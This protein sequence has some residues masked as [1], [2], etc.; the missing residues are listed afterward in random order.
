MKNKKVKLVIVLY[1]LAFVLLS[2]P[3]AYGIFKETKSKELNLSITHPSFTVTFNPTGG[4]V[5]PTS[6]T[7]T[8]GHIYDALPTPSRTG[9]GFDG[10]YDAETGGNRVLAS[11]TVEK[12]EN[13]TLF[14]H[15][16]ANSLIV[17]GETSI[18]FTY[19]TTSQTANI[20]EASNGSGNYTYTEKSESDGTNNTNYISLSGTEITVAPSTPAGIYTYIVTVKDTTSGAEVDV[21]YTIT[22][23][24]KKVT[25]PTCGTFTYN[26]SEQTLIASRDEY[27]AAD[28]TAINAGDYTVKLTPTSNY[29][30]NDNTV[31]VKN[32]SC[33]IEKYDISATGH[34]TVVP[35][36]NKI[37]NGSYFTPTP[38]VTVPLPSSIT[39]YT[40]TSS[41]V[42][43][44]YANNKDAGEATITIAGAGNYTGVLTEHFTIEKA[45]G[46]INLSEI[47]KAVVYGTSSVSFTVSSSHGGEYSVSDNNATATSSVSG[48][49]VTVGNIGTLTSGTVVVVTVTSDETNNYT[50]AS[51]TYTLTI[52]NAVLS[53]G[54]VTI[55]GRNVV[56]ETLTADV[57]DTSPAATYTYEWYRNTSASTSGGTKI[58]GATGSTYQVA[59]EDVGSYIYVVVTATKTNYTSTTFSDVV[60]ATHNT[61]ATAKTAVQ[62]PTSTYCKTLAY[63]GSAQVLTNTA[64]TGFA[65][66]DNSGTNAGDYTV[67]A[68]LA[69][70]Y[71]WADYTS[72]DASIQCSISPKA[73]T[74]TSGSSTREYNGLPL[75]NNTCTS[76][77]L[78]S[79]DT[80]SCTMTTAST[81]T[82]KGSQNN[83]IST[84]TISNGTDVV[85]SNY[86]VATAHG[87]LTVTAATPTIELT[88]KTGMVWNNTAQRANTATVSLV[89]NETY[90]GT[91]TYT[92]YTD[93]SC[94]TGATTTAPTLAGYYYVKATTA[95]FGNYNA[96]ASSC[97]SHT[98]GLRT[99]TVTLTAK[100]ASELVY[101]GSPIAANL[102]SVAPNAGGTVTYT[103]YT[104]NTCTA[105][106][107]TTAPTNAGTYYVKA[108]VS[109]VANKT[110]AAE[111]GCINH[112]ITQKKATITLTDSSKTLTYKTSGTNTYTYDGDG[113]VNC[114]SS[115]TSIVS[116]SVDSTNNKINVVPVAASANAVT[117]TV[118]A[119]AGS[120][121][122]APNNKTFTV[123]VNKATPT[124]T[125]TE[126]T[127]MVWNNTA[128]Q[129]NTAT[130][131]LVNSET[132]SGTVTYTYYTNSGCSSGAT[133]T[134][135]TLAG[136]YYVKATTASFGNYNAGASSCVA[137]TIGLRTPTVT[138][139]EK[140]AANRVYTGSGIAA[141]TAT[142]APNAGGA[143]TYTYYT[144]SECTTGGTTAAPISV[145]TY[146]VKASVA[147]V[148][149]KTT[150]AS[151]SCV[152]HSITQKKATITLTDSTKTL[153]YKTNGTNSFTYDGDGTLS[154][155]SSDTTKVTCSVDVANNLVTVIPQAATSSAVTITVSAGNGINY[156]AADDKTF[157]VT[158]NKYT[159]TVTLAAKSAPNRVYTGSAITANTATVTLTNGETYS[160]TIT[161]TY[162][163]NSTC[164]TGATTT[165][166]TNVGTYYVKATTAAFGNYN[167]GASACVNHSITQKEAT[168]TLTDS[169]KTL[170]YKTSGTNAYTYDGDGTISC[171]S[172]DTTKVTCSVDTTNHKINV[173]PVA[174]TTSAVT[175]TVSATAGSNYSAAEDK[176]FTVT[177]NKY[178]PT[179]TLT[180]K[181]AEDRVYTGSPIVANTATVALTNSE[182]YSGTITYTYYTNSTCTTGATTTAPTNVGTY[183]VKATTAAFGNYNAGASAC[184]NH[185]ITNKIATITLADSTMTLTYKTS[186]T[187][188]YTYDGDGTVSCS[189]SNT[190]KVTCSVDTTNHKIN[191]VPV[192][193]TTSAVTITVSA[194]AGA[195]YGPAENKTFTVTVN[196]ATPT[197]TLTAKSAE[198]R[199]YTGS[200]IA[201]NTATVTLVN[202]ETYSG[203]ITYTYY[204]NSTCTTGATTTAPTNVGTYYAKAS[205]AAFGN[206]NAA[207]SACVNH[208]ITNKIATIT[209]TDATKT[210]TYKTSGTNAYT[211]DGDGSVS[212]SSSDTTKVTCSVDAVNHKITV[213]PQAATTSAVTIT[214][215]A[216]AGSNY[217]PAEDKT[218][219]VT[220]NK[221][222]P[223]VTLTEKTGM[224]WNNTA[225]QANTATVTLVN[226]E[227]YSGTI[228]YTYYT[229][230]TCTT[231]ATTTAPTLAGDYY[232][233]ATT[234]AFGNYN[235]GA[236]SCV[237]HTIG[238]RTPT[239]TLNA[240]NSSELVYTGSPIAAN[241]A[242]VAPNAGGTVTYTY[243]TNSACTTGATTTA[244]TAVGTYYVK[245]SVAAVANKT[246]TADSACV[247][248]SITAK[249]A[250]ITLTDTSKTLTYGTSGT[251]SY[252]YD[253]DGTVSCSSSDTSVVTCSVDSTNH[254]INI[255]PVAA[256]A[257]AVTIT[258]SAGAGSNYSAPTNKTFTVVVNKATP[259]ISLTEKTG[260]VWNNTAQQANTATVTLVNSET[261]SGT[262]TYTYYT[263]SACSTGATTTAPTLAGNYYVKATTAAFGNYNAGASSCVAHTIDL[264]TPTVTLSAKSAN[265]LV[266]TGS[267]IAA[268]TATVAPNAGGA[269]TYTYY[270]N[271]TCTTGATTTAPTNVGTYYVKASVAAVAN[272]TTA[273]ESSC[274]AH[275][276]TQKKATI[277]LTDSSKTLT[278]KT[279][280]TNAYTYDG[281]GTLSCSSS[282]TTK[283]TCSVDT[284]NNKINIVPVAATTSAVT[285]TVSATA[286]SNYSAPDNKT[287][288]V[289]VNKFT[290]TV[291]LTAKSAEDRVYTGSPIVANT[292]TV[293]LTN[294]ETY[295]GTITYTY[296]TNS[297][298]TTGA[299]TTAPTN[300]GT[301]YV[302][303]T[304]SAFG[305]Y[306]AGASAC[307]NHSITKN[308]ATITITDSSKTLTYG[309]NGTNS[310]TYNGDGTVS[311]SSTN[312]S[313]VTCSVDTTNHKINLV[314]VAYTTSAVTITVSAS[315]GANYGIAE[316]KT[317]TVTV[318]KATPTV[319]LTEKSA[320]Q[321]V[322]TGSPITANTA[323][324]ALVNSETYTGSIGYTY[325]TDSACS[326]G[327]TTAPT[328]AGTYYVKATTAAFGNYNAGASACVNHSITQKKATITLTDSSKTLTYKT[329]GTN[330]YTYD[331]D[332]T[333]GCA[334]AD[335]TKVT[336]SVDTTNHVIEIVPVAATTSPVTLTISAG[337]GTNYSA[338][339]SKTFT[340]TV[341]KFTPTVSLTEKTGMVWNNAAQ[342]A[343]TATVTLT[344][345]ETFSRTITYTYYTN[346]TCTT[347]ATT[348]TPTL[349]GNY[350]V[351]AS[352]DAYG[353]Y[354]AAASS[355]VA[356]T[357]ALKTPTV[358]LTAKSSSEL[359]YTGSPIPSNT[360][361]V[362]T[363]NGGS[364]IVYKYYTNNS[365]TVEYKSV[366]RPAT[367]LHTATCN[368][369]DSYGCDL[370][371]SVGYGN[372]ITYGTLVNGTPKAGDAY[373][374]DVNNDG[375]Y[376][377]ATERFYYLTNDG[378]NATLIYYKNMNNLTTYAYDSSNENWHGPR[379]A[380]SYLP[381]TTDWDNPSLIAPGTRYIVSTDGTRITEGGT[382]DAFTYTNRAARLLTSQEVN[383]A[384]GI[385]VGSF[386]DGEINGCNYLLEN[387]GYFE[388]G[389][390][391]VGYWLE[392]PE[393]DCD[394]GIWMTLGARNSIDGAHADVSTYFGVR[395]V[396]TVAT[397][398]LG[399]VPTAVGTYYAQ[400][401]VAAVENKT[402][403]AVSACVNHSITK[404]TAT[405]TV[406]SASKSITYGATGTNGYT[407]TGDGSVSCASSDSTKVICS[408]DSTNNV[409]N[410]VPVGA[411]TSAVTITLSA[412]AGPN[413]NAPSNK[414]FTVTVVKATPTVSLTSRTGMV[415]NDQPYPANTATVT[416]V[417][418]ETY[419]GIITYTYYTNNS[420]TNNATTDAPSLGRTYYVKATTAAFGNYNAGSSSCVTH[421]IEVA[422][423][424]VTLTPKTE[425]ERAYTG[426][427]IVA[428]TATLVPN[429]GATI[430]YRYYTD[431]ACTTGTTTTAPKNVGTYYAKAFA[432]AVSNKTAA[433]SSECV[434]HSIVP[435][436]VN[437]VTDLAVST[438]GVVTWTNSSNATGYE[439]SIDGINWT[440]VPP[441]TNTTTV[442]YL[443]EITGATGTRTVYVKAV[444][445]NTTNYAS[446]NSTATKDVSVYALTF[447]TNN[448][449]YGVVD[450]GSINVI[451]GATYTAS[452]NT[453]NISDGRSAIATVTNLIG[454]TTVFSNWSSN[455]GTVNAAT[456][457]TATFNRQEKIVTITFNSNT[458]AFTGNTTT[459]TV[460]YKEVLGEST[461]VSHTQN[462]DDTGYQVSNYGGSWT[463]ANITGTDRGDTTK[464]HVITMPGSTSLTV[465]V[466]YNGESTSYDWVNVWE[467]SH[468]DYTAAGNYSSS[469]S[470]KLGGSQSGS[471]TVNGNSLTNMGHNTFTISGESVTFGFK[472]DGSGYG[473]G[474]GYYAIVSGLGAVYSSDSGTYQ[475]PS[476][477]RYVFT[478]WNTAA[479]GSGTSYLT[480]SSLST[481]TSSTTLYAQYRKAVATFDEGRVFNAAIKQLSGQSSATYSTS[482]TT[483]TA[484]TK[485]TGT[486]TSQTLADAVL[487]S[488]ASSEADIYAWF[489]NG[490]IYWY[491]TADDVYF[492]ATSTNMFYNLNGITTLDLSPFDASRIT[493]ASSMLSSMSAIETIITPKVHSSSSLSLPVT[494]ID[495]NN[496]TYS[497]ITS[498]MTPMTTLKVP[499]TITFDLNGGTNTSCINTTKLIYPGNPLGDIPEITATKVGYTLNGW[500]TEREGGTQVTSATVPP[501]SI[502]YYARWTK[503]GVW[504][505]DI[506]YDNSNTGLAC[507]SVQCV[508]DYFSQFKEKIVE[509]KPLCKRAT[510]L[511]TEQCTQSDTTQYCRSAGYSLNGTITYGNASTTSGVLAAGDA[512]DCDV[513]ADGV[514]DPVTERF[515]YVS[516][517]YDTSTK[518]FNSNVAVLIYYSNTSSG[519]SSNS[520]NAYNVA[521]NNYNGP[522]SAISDLPTVA[523]WSNVTL[524]KN[525]RKI[526]TETDETLTTGGNLPTSYSYAGYAA[527]FLTYQEVN[528]NCSV[529]NVSIENDGGI[530]SC[531][532]LVEKTVFASASNQT[533]GGWLETP[534]RSYATQATHLCGVHNHVGFERVTTTNA[535]GARPA[536][537]VPKSR[538][539]Y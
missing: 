64:G 303:A 362:S 144:D 183:Y 131:T 22:I 31:G 180:A 436:P 488:S 83:Y 80:A 222:T 308:I 301:Y 293:T 332:G 495:I 404:K 187:N 523:Q 420:C 482:N 149:N 120:N 528:Q 246:T 250:T 172:S 415:W 156:S 191:V 483:I 311:C 314:P 157:T 28:N 137:H 11:T 353:N 510:T 133:T 347:G 532:F 351:K 93:S 384:C 58:D 51:A 397:G 485:Y 535:N 464:A 122:S 434:N 234:A 216:S 239:V 517:Y 431:S 331:G 128:Q 207:S 229:N 333:V 10:W 142:V 491:T 281:D 162:Y 477:D 467:G 270:T 514:Y 394:A 36:S 349:A 197:V 486:P 9:F 163:T 468:P 198:D 168:I 457:I 102:A 210:L 179:V 237:A 87:V 186:G 476:K 539:D 166:P 169:S 461:K 338:A 304:T 60:D 371:G 127:G 143:I 118:S 313:K 340:V 94:T 329:N 291:T 403:A 213:V 116:C 516:D 489:E 68:R 297:G 413:Y 478:G 56:G 450:P 129:A 253:G 288:T 537:D 378:T 146:Y 388:N 358:T 109:A 342:A 432:A 33:T 199:V 374:C 522:V 515:Y 214:V 4:T 38:A 115:D 121:Y 225:Q 428:N 318:N 460:V 354:N 372:T 126:K 70:G 223:T 16:N 370:S 41:E 285:L 40:L 330:A 113:T 294:S 212:C 108:S 298:C 496:T 188:A 368:R 240:K 7:V 441:G 456:T 538:I 167:A 6:K 138:L 55:S 74:L 400:A 152:N 437:P 416:L 255:V 459:N 447:A 317:F 220:V 408:V 421:K 86:Q 32:V 119:T 202:S 341:N 273:A 463:N 451:K 289:T 63:N 526:L 117:I 406:A 322:Y 176:T 345:G 226:S 251:N 141:N 282:D 231:G 19:S 112:S 205:I 274:V 26:K 52:S 256:S 385:T 238:L 48:N 474:Y 123:V 15:W 442:N 513:N 46:Y 268:N 262:L 8:Y 241:L 221:A 217:G 518:A 42:N 177:V 224:T 423:P 266:Y 365:C 396:I 419:T 103:Y 429:S 490:T 269:V 1:V 114:A 37:Y 500:Y 320:S 479:D 296:Y 327:A 458:G 135:P 501:S 148:A 24:R 254:K 521:D 430:T 73:I 88:E 230:S 359:V 422:T 139:T 448:A 134:A 100:S 110:T 170:T 244:P 355:C 227:T 508:L 105:G 505:E 443:T 316:N 412:T 161:Y 196:K 325:Y 475:V 34:A 97:V 295:S 49:T 106:A 531:N 260:M 107:T 20:N 164:T 452:G 455:S 57:T 346:S 275:S 264:R 211:Y 435:Q 79:G 509:I 506:E 401:S 520:T 279:S 335:T 72:T 150:A 89:N 201:A 357:I 487:V 324:V 95:A 309:T 411:T 376:D 204:T 192:A 44:S 67:K 209:L 393:T 92:Y 248:H 261:Y 90:S 425:S 493:S 25:V 280:G 151:S 290:P 511:H 265:E 299:T 363:P 125:L 414:T 525:Q 242:S 307:V 195:N 272:K 259:T 326:T 247:N 171:S 360:A 243:Y 344:N 312:T 383:S 277:T 323:T 373:D 319:T 271:S 433:A 369:N 507:E 245:A 132:Y 449:L 12:T 465:D 334:S 343:N 473:K 398:D 66:Y 153:T 462:V 530:N 499:Y 184:V 43:Y 173:V 402:T 76:P 77:D 175:I 339:D 21:I 503:S 236:S 445:S 160:G 45:D 438:S 321:R 395:P 426:S 377:P 328:N 306:N 536:I 249:K 91:I 228:T 390:G 278:Y 17:E 258:V 185:S 283:V 470:G 469:V 502:S 481:I 30:W 174:A 81:I 418:G 366:C 78:I 75:T 104:N 2:I 382:I 287:F 524:Y 140:S 519:V 350:Y 158:V 71:I 529:N 352:I 154:C 367:T 165:A 39:T 263:N 337:A 130:V 14:A 348:T 453:I 82:N 47:S 498:S 189:S 181:S 267:P 178:T 512:F 136:N 310:Y 182:T 23:G 190:S 315:A 84:Y 235:A 147:A 439:I 284:T 375:V 407:Y 361:T 300:V 424:V 534:K 527:R 409:I 399:S 446:T 380:Y 59:T 27:T 101:T 471:Y 480:E 193:Y 69:E 145:G 208:S 466:Y 410:L 61:T 200:P 5:S 194:G 252:A 219:T 257:S 494:M 387:I 203:T 497:S 159:P 18:G 13:H 492:N 392:T 391:V 50:S 484:F 54:S 405:I 98:I 379:S 504:A 533:Y 381:S 302:K 336:C 85:T 364:P 111:S 96:G 440:S 444:N 356:H 233:K 215:S 206:Y 305:N 65:F 124:I 292:A 276:I 427:N 62:K 386:V 99:P 417:N 232:V 53:G 35:T 29:Q 218:F 155:A 472:S 389:S 3:F 454:Y 286:G